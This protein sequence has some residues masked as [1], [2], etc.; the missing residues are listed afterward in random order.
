MNTNWNTKELIEE[1]RNN[2][3]CIIKD[4]FSEQDLD[5]IKNSLLQTLH[6]IK[7]D[8][9]QD[10]QKKYYQIKKYNPK[11][12][13]NWYDIAHYN[14]DLRQFFYTP[15]L[16]DLVKEYFNTKV[17][18][19]GR[20][21]IHVHDD[22][23][24]FLLEPHQETAMMAADSILLWSPLYDTNKE[25]GGLAV[26]KD[27]H[28]EGYFEHTLQ[29]PTLT[30]EKC[31][32]DNYTHVDPSVSKRFEKIYLEIKAGT[33]ILA[34]SSVLHCGYPTQKKGSVRI[35]LTERYTPLKRLPFL[36]NV[37]APRTIPYCGIDY[38]KIPD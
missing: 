9:E 33:A 30:E 16:V 22:A 38:N 13:G 27:S 29:H 10:L 17:L 12:K 4:L 36:R 21:C 31:W 8:D 24:K 7:P 14:I 32:T 23:N 18:F 34:Q 15:A 37:N 20:P 1:I 6:Y 2:G 3:F 28:K 26:Y 35:V 5:K 11:L 19:S 25:N